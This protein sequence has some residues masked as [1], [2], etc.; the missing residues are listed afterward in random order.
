MIAIYDDHDYGKD[1]QGVSF[2]LKH[3]GKVCQNLQLWYHFV[4]FCRKDCH[5]FDQN[6]YQIH[7]HTSLING[8]EFLRIKVV[9]LIIIKMLKNLFLE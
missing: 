6:W 5:I 1:N 7:H 4:T 9:E 3:I 8:N 2:S